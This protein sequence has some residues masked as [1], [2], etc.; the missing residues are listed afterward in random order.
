MTRRDPAGRLRL[1]LDMFT[2]GSDL[3]RLS[4]RRR[5]PEDGEDGL[6]ERFRGW[7]QERDGHSD[8]PHLRPRPLP[9]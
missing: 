7:L 4:L 2:T 9:G 1:A 8:P 6:A 5:H 3:Q